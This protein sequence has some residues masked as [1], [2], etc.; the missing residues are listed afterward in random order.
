MALIP[1][2]GVPSSDRVPGTY[3]ELLF[4]QG[5]SSAGAGARDAVYVVPMLA[6]GTAQANQLV[7]VKNEGSAQDLFA[8]GSMA[9]RVCRMHFNVNKFNKVYVLP[10]NETSADGTAADGYIDIDGT[11][12]ASGVLRA[13]VCGEAV[14]VAVTT[15][16]TATAIGDLLEGAINAKTWLPCTASNDAGRVT[17]TAKHKGKSQGDGTTGVIRFRASVSSGTGLTISVSGKALGLGVGT[18]GVDGSTTEADNFAAALSIINNVRRYYVTT[19]LWDS[20][21][22]ASLKTH[23]NSKSEPIAGHRSVGIFGFTGT[24]AA[25]STLSTALNFERMQ[26]AWFKNSE[27]DVA[28]IVAQMTAIRQKRETT[29]SAY[30]FDFYPEADWVLKPQYESA[31]IADHN[32]LNDAISDGIT[33]ITTFG[34][35]SRLVYS[36]T[37]R[38]KTSAGTV[39]DPRGLETHRISVADEVADTH[40]AR[41][42]ATYSNFR[43]QDDER[44]ADGSINFAQKIGART[45]TPFKYSKFIAGSVLNPF[46]PPST[47]GNGRLQNIQASKDSIT[48]NI[49]PNNSG[50]LE[51]G[52]DIH[53]TD[54]CHQITIR[55]A[56]VSSG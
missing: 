43:L 21:S 24:L 26:N 2:T 15:D 41:S 51:C 33:P 49:D 9:H 28:E 31:D 39:F 19:T 42:V 16:D 27:H 40:I 25:A 11:A 37:T 3:L 8:P 22:L 5:Q 13:T 10:F 38:S 12:T 34:N 30:N 56:E 50:R 48:T 52:Y 53:V 14:D 55:I 44:L 29:D 47:K 20:T 23:L 1:I 45:L 32:D 36:A 6:A 18:P 17:L 7:Q 46:G 35:V 54:L 4:N